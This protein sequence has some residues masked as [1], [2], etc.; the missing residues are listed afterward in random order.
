MIDCMIVSEHSFS[1]CNTIFGGYVVFTWREN[2][3]VCAH[4]GGLLRGLQNLF[5]NRI[6]P[7]AHPISTRES[8]TNDEQDEHSDISVSDDGVDNIINN[9]SSNSVSDDD[10]YTNV[11]NSCRVIF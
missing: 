2:H 5:R 11:Q 3:R 10:D 4:R 6:P 8:I 7:P 1:F 9:D